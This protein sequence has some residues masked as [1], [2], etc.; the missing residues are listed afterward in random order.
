M[1]KS[2][3]PQRDVHVLRFG[4]QILGLES[5]VS[6]PGLLSPRPVLSPPQ[7]LAFLRSQPQGWPR[8]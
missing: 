4:E 8:L 3:G 1:R 5:R 2:R 7:R 6:N